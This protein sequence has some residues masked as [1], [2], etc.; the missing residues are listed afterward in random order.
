MRKVLVILLVAAILAT[1]LA[2]CGHN[3]EKDKLYTDLDQF[4]R[5][6]ERN[7]SE[8]Y[9]ACVIERNYMM[10]NNILK[11]SDDN[12]AEIALRSFI[13]EDSPD[14]D[15]ITGR[16]SEIKDLHEAIQA[17]QWANDK[18][19]QIVELEKTTWSSLVA[20]YG[21][22]LQP[23]GTPLEFKESFNNWTDI[24]DVEVDEIRAFL[25]EK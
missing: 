17:N 14:I 7:N 4:Q 10:D 8:I 20:M 13:S 2:G 24:I 11:A 3:E 12:Y 9:A 16:M 15:G 22:M 5:L 1:S 6:V 19:P 21:L 25:N 23:E 18:A